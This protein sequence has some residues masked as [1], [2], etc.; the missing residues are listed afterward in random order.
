MLCNDLSLPLHRSL[1]VLSESP[2]RGSLPLLLAC[3]HLREHCA[4][5]SL[6]FNSHQPCFALCSPHHSF[7]RALYTL[8]FAL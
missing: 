8:C 2:L 1:E 7:C 4:E 6:H 5:S 3:N